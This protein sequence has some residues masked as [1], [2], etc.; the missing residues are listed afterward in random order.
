MTTT[1]SLT[2]TVESTEYQTRDYGMADHLAM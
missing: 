1:V 2:F